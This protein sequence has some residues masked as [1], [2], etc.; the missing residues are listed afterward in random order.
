MPTWRN[1]RRAAFRS[2]SFHEGEGSSPFVGTTFEVKK[3]ETPP[4][5]PH[6]GDFLFLVIFP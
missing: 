3:G 5:H 1:G 4:N 6:F 2:Q